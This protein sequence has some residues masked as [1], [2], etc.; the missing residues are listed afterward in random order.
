VVH[1]EDPSRPVTQ[2]LFR[3]EVTHDFTNGLADMLDV[4]GANYRDRELFAAQRAVP[5]R[6]ILGTEERHDREV[7]LALRDSPSLAGQF[8]WAGVDY[9]GEADWPYL[10]SSAGLLDRTGRLKPRAYQRQSWWSD[11]PMVRIARIEPGLADSDPRRRYGYD[12]TCDWTPRESATYIEANVEVYSNCDE[13]ELLL[14]GRSLGTRSQPADASPRRWTVPFEPGTIKAVASNRGQ[15]VATDD[16]HTAGAPARLVLATDRPRIAERWD[17]VAFV[18][19]AAVDAHG[20]PCPWADTTVHF[21]LT[22]PGVIAAVDNGDSRDPTPFQSAE[23]R[24]F[25]GECVALVKAAASAGEIT[26]TVS[27][28][29]LPEA[30]IKLTAT[31]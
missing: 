20:V 24:L 25:R 1:A 27:A 9:L 6:R 4:I 28:N 2:A 10:N 21:T 22:G 23:R 15:I 18:T 19:V 5:A 30:S 7:W 13:V 26:V 31:P 29:G 12:R 11:E 8:L 3:P 17:D 16:L 14:N